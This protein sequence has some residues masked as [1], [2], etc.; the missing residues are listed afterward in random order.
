MLQKHVKG[1]NSEEELADLKK[2]MEGLKTTMD[3]SEEANRNATAGI[4]SDLTST[5]HE[6]LKVQEML[7]MTE[8][9]LEKKGCMTAPFKNLKQLL[10]RKNEQIK[11]LRRSLA[12]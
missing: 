1:S 12:K 8:N 9:E 7:E 4:S 5:K 10:V 6:L 3:M 2:T 11:E